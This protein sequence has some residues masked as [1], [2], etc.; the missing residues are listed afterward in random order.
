MKLYPALVILTTV[1][2]LGPAA[3][4]QTCYT[5]VKSWQGSYNMTASGTV[6]P[7]PNSGICSVSQSA[8]AD[9]NFNVAS[10]TCDSTEWVPKSGIDSNPSFNL[11]NSWVYPCDEG[12]ETETITG[13]GT[14]LQSVSQLIITTSGSTYTPYVPFSAVE[15]ATVELSGSCGSGNIPYSA[16]LAPLQNWPPALTLP[17]TVAPLSLDGYQ[18]QATGEGVGIDA[19][20]PWTGSFTLSPSAD[21]KPCRQAGGQ[22]LPVSSSISAQTQS[23]GEDVPIVG[24]EFRLH[25]ESERAPAPGAGN[26][27]STD[28]AM[29]GGWTLSVHHAYDINS[30]T[31]F[32]GD[33]NQRN[34]YELGTPVSY[35]GDL[36][37]TSQDGAEVYVFSPAGQHLQTLRLPTGALLYSF[38]Y[39]TAGNLITITDATGNVTKIERNASEQPT[40][41]VSPYGQTTTLAVDGNGFLSQVTDPLGNSQT[42]VNSSGDLLSTRTDANG[43][44]FTY[45]YDSNGGLSKDADPLGG[46]VTLTRTNANT[47]LGWTV[48]ELTSMGVT[49]S[50]TPTLSI[51]WTQDGTQPQSEQQTMIWPD[52]LQATSTAALQSGQLSNN[53]ALPD[54]TTETRP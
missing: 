22:G 18:F 5:P 6:I 40:A 17:P 7:C 43:N 47:G 37:L 54:G 28:A 15:N 26:I 9:V 10:V 45:T 50:Y 19:T 16:D 53:V 36:L 24:T 39:D 2:T 20:I 29:I 52:G 44:I 41:I 48:A 13:L 33:G 31:L 14:G 42:F 21:C 27:A 49:S 30:N 3:R 8:T 34:G 35:N 23:L 46:Y 11:N 1:F 32:L 38:A 12:N 51:P 4:A 25:Y